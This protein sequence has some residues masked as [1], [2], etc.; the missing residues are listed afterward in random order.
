M[1]GALY[2]SF[3]PIWNIWTSD[4]RKQFL[5]HL[6]PYVGSSDNWNDALNKLVAEGIQNLRK[7]F[8]GNEL[9][10]DLAD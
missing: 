4:S 9:T 5:I 7:C 6:K 2:R 3:D 10:A 1:A 8:K